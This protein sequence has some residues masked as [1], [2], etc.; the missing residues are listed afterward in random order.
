MIMAIKITFLTPM[1]VTSCTI[2]SIMKPLCILIRKGQLKILKTI[3]YIHYTS[4]ELIYDLPYQELS[5]TDIVH[6]FN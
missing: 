4:F 6:P 1:L 3:L 5:Y 2:L